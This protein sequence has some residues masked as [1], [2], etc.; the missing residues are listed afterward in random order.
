M[1]DNQRAQL[2]AGEHKML[3]NVEEEMEEQEGVNMMS[4]MMLSNGGSEHGV[5]R[6]GL[7]DD[8]LYLDNRSTVTAVKNKEFLKNLRDA[9][10]DL[11]VSY[12]A[13]VAKASQLGDLGKMES[14]YM[15]D[16]IANILSQH[17]VEQKYHVTYDSWDGFYVVHHPK[18][19]VK[20][21]KDHQ[22][23]PFRLQS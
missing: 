2:A 16:G 12:N 23:L 22:G 9:E 3:M 15:P 10:Q 8:R 14:W 1:S 18:G 13:G 7:S 5:R 11:S 4:V 17:Q 19:P 6:N 21:C 20:C